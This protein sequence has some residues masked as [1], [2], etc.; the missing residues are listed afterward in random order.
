MRI[1]TRT[2]SPRA[3]TR[4]TLSAVR[5]STLNLLLLQDSANASEAKQ[6]SHGLVI[7]RSPS[8]RCALEH[9]TLSSFCAT[10][11]SELHPPRHVGEPR[12]L[13][14]TTCNAWVF[15]Y[16]SCATC[17]NMQGATS[18]TEM[19]TP[20]S[21]AYFKGLGLNMCVCSLVFS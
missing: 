12:R 20:T 13:L 14:R 4:R 16:Y 10:Q 19:L 11:E 3:T 1:S 8:T 18:P 5:F 7:L 2:R 17:E 15:I 9:Q 21:P 6:A